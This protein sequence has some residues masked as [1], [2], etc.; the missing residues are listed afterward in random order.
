[1]SESVETGPVALSRLLDEIR[2]DGSWREET[3]RDPN[4][5]AA[6][7]AEPLRAPLPDP[8]LAAALEALDAAVAAA[9]GELPVE[10]DRAVL[11]EAIAA[12]RRKLHAEL[13][14]Y[15]ERQAL[16]NRQ[17]GELLRRLAAQLDPGQPDAA[18]AELWTALGQ[19]DARMAALEN[20]A[21]LARVDRSQLAELDASVEALA[22]E[23][24]PLGRVRLAVE[25]IEQRID[26][27]E[28]GRPA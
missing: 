16:V 20:A 25:A 4:G 26:A 22:Q 6:P 13:R 24:E 1:M 9:A 7:S 19:L 5:A 12:L 28:R 11:G 21:A 14:I 27:V 10:S 17:T 15:Q 8:A 23:V 2:R 3:G 18:L